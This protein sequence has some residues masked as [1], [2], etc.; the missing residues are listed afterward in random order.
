M[1]KKIILLIFAIVFLGG[2]TAC[3]T[4]ENLNNEILSGNFII[5]N[6]EYNVEKLHNQL[7]ENGWVAD[8]YAEMTLRPKFKS[9]VSYYHDDYGKD[10]FD[11]HI[12]VFYYNN[13]DIDVNILEAPI[14]TIIISK[15]RTEVYPTFG[16]GTKILSDI[17]I[18]EVRNNT[19]PS[20]VEESYI[21]YLGN[22][23]TKV[24]NA[25]LNFDDEKKLISIELSF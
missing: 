19:Q 10:I 15:E 25:R 6:K 17:T 11:F 22:N 5:A 14:Q 23:N 2:L 16:L 21:E 18:D 1:K 13:S 20:I 24:K 9:I 7:V 12:D 8:E 3:G 4:K